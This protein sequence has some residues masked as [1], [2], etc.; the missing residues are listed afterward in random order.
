MDSSFYSYL[1]MV[2]V[3]VMIIVNDLRKRVFNKEAILY[4]VK[5][6]KKN[7]YLLFA[8]GLSI[9]GVI[10]ISGVTLDYPVETRVILLI[11]GGLMAI[12]W[13]LISL[14]DGL[15]TTTHAGKVWFTNLTQAE[16]YGIMVHAGKTYFTF[17]R[18]KAKRQET[19][20]VN[21]EDIEPIKK[22]LNDLGIKIYADYVKQK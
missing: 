17:K 3:C 19:L 6:Q 4:R 22:I 5:E 9:P 1:A 10:L 20:P 11:F 12:I 13:T 16:Y 2:V 7:K 15:I 8:M 14:A 21:Y 18:A